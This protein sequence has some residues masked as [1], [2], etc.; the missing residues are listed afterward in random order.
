[1][2]ATKIHAHALGLQE[3][4]LT[5]L[6]SLGLAALHPGQLVVPESARRGNFLTFRTPEAGKIYEALLAQNVITD[7]RADRLRF[8]FGL[9]QD[10]DDVVRLCSVLGR[11]ID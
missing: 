8:G 9:Y 11:I 7:Y 3:S 1:M 4:F 2:D 10:D 6:T 5:G